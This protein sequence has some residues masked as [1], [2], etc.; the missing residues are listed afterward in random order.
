MNETTTLHPSTDDT[1]YEALVDHYISEMKLLQKHMAEDR[2]EI[3]RLQ[4]ET[5]G[6][7]DDIM[8]TLKAE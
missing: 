4:V 1:N 3:L 5:R 8:A 2:E 7:L 6:I